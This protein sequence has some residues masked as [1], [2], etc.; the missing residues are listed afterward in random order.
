[1]DE[2]E[3]AGAA[4]ALLE[5]FNETAGQFRATSAIR[6]GLGCPDETLLLPYLDARTF[7]PL[8]VE[9]E[10]CAERLA[11]IVADRPWA[12]EALQRAAKAALE[13]WLAAQDRYL[14][15]LRELRVRIIGT[16]GS[17]DNQTG[18][19]SSAASQTNPA[20][21]AAFFS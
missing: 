8:A 20:K 7:D 17:T 12:S 19:A 4:P 1:M 3:R 2:L 18:P 14:D 15:L 21:L 11:A 13:Q 6:T 10:A 16:L 5:R 9:M